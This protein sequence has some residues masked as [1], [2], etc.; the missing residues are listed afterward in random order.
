LKEPFDIGFSGNVGNS[1]AHRR[2]LFCA[3]RQSLL[4]NV[5]DVHS[6]AALGKCTGNRTAYPGAASGHQDAQPPSYFRL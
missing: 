1:A 6:R 3:M 2:K 5:A 4:G